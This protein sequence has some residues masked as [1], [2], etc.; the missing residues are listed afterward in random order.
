MGK[1]G[2]FIGLVTALIA[3]AMPEGFNGVSNLAAMNL[4][5]NLV[6]IG[7]ALFLA[8]VITTAAARVSNA[9]ARED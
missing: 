7:S 8:G 2:A 9:L 6:I 1:V 4:K 5:T 3:L